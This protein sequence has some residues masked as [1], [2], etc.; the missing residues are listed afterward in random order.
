MVS[1]VKLIDWL[2]EGYRGEWSLDDLGWFVVSVIGVATAL[3]LVIAGL[4]LGKWW[5]G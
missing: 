2:M 3:A 4:L 5:S 1:E